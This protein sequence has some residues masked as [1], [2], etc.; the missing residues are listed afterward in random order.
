MEIKEKKVERILEWASDF[1]NSQ[2]DAETNDNNA[3]PKEEDFENVVIEV[4]ISKDEMSAY[5]EIT[6]NKDGKKLS[7]DYVINELTAKNVSYGIDKNKIKEVVDKSIYYTPIE[8]AKGTAPVNGENGLVKYHF[9]AK[10]DLKPRVSQDGRADFHN[11]D[12]IINVKKGQLLAEII[13]RTK[14]VPGTTV[15]NKMLPAKDGREAHVVKGK[16][17]VVSED[18]LKIY[19]NIDGQPVLSSNKISV[20]PV[21]EIKVD[22]GPATGNI[23]FLG[24]VIVKGNVKS[25][26]KIEAEGD[27]EVEGTVEDAQIVAKGNIVLKRGM[28]GRGIGIVKAG[29]DVVARY[30][31]NTNVY[32]AQNIIISEAVMHSNLS[33]G[34]K[35][36]LNGRKGLLV[37]GT[38][39][40]GEELIAKVIGS[41]MSTYT[42]IN[43][44]IN[45]EHRKDYQGAIKELRQIDENLK[46]IKQA[47]NI[48][49]GLENR[50]LLSPDKKALMV[51]LEN[52]QASLLKQQTGLMNEKEK[53]DFKMEHLCRAKVSA[54]D[55]I[56]AG[57]N[58]LI[59]NAS[60]KLRDKVN[61]STFYNYEGQI[62]FGSYEG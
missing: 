47:L 12:L 58:I 5:V 17:V 51:K 54:S 21:L 62:R 36:E 4:E 48:L 1:T 33:A 27:V 30:I 57:V 14:G 6:P 37:G 53:N 2:K 49:K 9:V 39:K 43:V 41:P 59:G 50:N 8:V 20:L 40:A 60:L 19:S 26:F 24:S 28:Q 61:H 35:I 42:E 46:K 25:G 34:K 38:A 18:K 11:L 7:L 10:K 3:K 16:N 55:V 23:V 22:V 44:G 32:A 15:T 29:Q 56:Y 52:S 13:P 45:P 31:E